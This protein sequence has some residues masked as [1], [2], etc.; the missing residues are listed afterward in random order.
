ME[1]KVF[2]YLLVTLIVILINV[3]TV[4]AVPSHKNVDELSY[5]PEDL[6]QYFQR[7]ADDGVLAFSSLAQGDIA[8]AGES[9]DSLGARLAPVRITVSSTLS[10]ESYLHEYFSPSAEIYDVLDSAREDVVYIQDGLQTL[11]FVANPSDYPDLMVSLR[12]RIDL[13]YLG[14][15]ALVPT[16]QALALLGIDTVELLDAYSDFVIL[17]E[18]YDRELYDIERLF[19][20]DFTFFTIRASPLDGAG[21]IAV[22]GLFYVGGEPVTNNAAVLYA[23][24][25][26]VLSGTTDENGHIL[27]SYRLPVPFSS[28]SISFHAQSAAAGV[29]YTSNTVTV[30]IEVPVIISLDKSYSIGGDEVTLN[31]Y[32]YLSGMIGGA[33][34]DRSVVVSINGES[35]MTITG[36]GGA[37][38]LSS[39]LPLDESLRITAYTEF[40]PESGEPYQYSRSPT[41]QFT[42]VRP[43]ELIDRDMPSGVSDAARAARENLLYILAASGVILVSAVIASFF[44]KKRKQSES[45]KSEKSLGQAHNIPDGER[46]LFDSEVSVLQQVGNTKEAIVVGYGALIGMLDRVGILPLQRD[47]TH[48]DID[49]TLR[50]LPYTKHEA[51]LITKAF[52]L[53]RY[54]PFSIGRRTYDAFIGALHNISGRIGDKR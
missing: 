28:S 27:F 21:I 29:V 39:T 2:R 32:G 11:S 16:F 46:D 42:I 36:P 4:A 23:N 15:D 18:S 35:F 51:P 38:S 24:G 13:L 9:I 26:V 31:L 5:D 8:G 6:V 41:L 19:S 3:S 52:E 12:E 33:L 7:C 17:L 1:T 54:S 49:S 37:Y 50:K 40:F 53:S 30:P 45:R 43:H 47:T 14:A 10:S 20:S 34:T 44:S 25:A 48:L 22:S